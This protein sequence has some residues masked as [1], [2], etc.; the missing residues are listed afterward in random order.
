MQED[1]IFYDL[2]GKNINTLSNVFYKTAIFTN[3]IHSPVPS[4]FIGSE[5]SGIK[6][7]KSIFL[8]NG[9]KLITTTDVDEFHRIVDLLGKNNSCD[10][11]IL[12]IDQSINLQNYYDQAFLFYVLEIAKRGDVAINFLVDISVTISYPIPQEINSRLFE[13]NTINLQI[14]DFTELQIIAQNVSKLDLII[15]P[16]SATRDYSDIVKIISLEL[17]NSKF[18]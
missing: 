11:F 13:F 8:E 3:A 7:C 10:R 15:D 5:K 18:I 6:V 2:G 16:Y 17:K 14:P 4:V 1:I 12:Y 9:F